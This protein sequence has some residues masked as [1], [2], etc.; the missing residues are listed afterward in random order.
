MPR[1]KNKE[2]YRKALADMFANILS[3]KGLLWKKDWL[4]K[5]GNA[6]QNAVTRVDYRG[7]N[8]INLI[9][10]A[11]NRGYTDPRWA[12]MVQIMD[13]DNKYHPDQKWHL[14]AGS[15]A[16]YVEYW[17]PFDTINKTALTWDKYDE[18]ISTGQRSPDE[19]KLSTRYTAVFN[20][21]DIEG[22]PE[23][24]FEER[25]KITSND[26]VN[27][28]SK[29]M[30]VDILYDG[31]DRAYYSPAED[32]IHLPTLESFTSEYGYNSTALHELAHSTG[33]PSRLN[34]KQGSF[35][36]TPEYAFEELIAEMASCFMS[37]N[38]ELEPS[39]QHLNNHKA[40][41]QGWI[42]MV[43]ERPETLVKAIKEAQTAAN[44]ME[45]KAGI[46]AEK[47]FQKNNASVR[48]F[49][50]IKPMPEVSLSL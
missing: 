37:V 27:T 10:T 21:T 30:G 41:V 39:E 12:T 8:Y 5:G 14:K 9:I 43:K 2:E 48:E 18:A 31:G 24:V 33:H 35:F 3:E 6:P 17:Y 29:E 23:F 28:L 22:I 15:K 38:L 44:Y 26:I 25:T 40:Y 42:K 16:V 20:A 36:G 19:F 1:P 11:V 34:R 13:K 47:E 46:I 49:T 50:V 45:Y 7:C 4:G 32:R